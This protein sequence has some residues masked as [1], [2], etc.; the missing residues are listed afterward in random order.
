MT[1][2]VRT[3]PVPTNGALSI[4]MLKFDARFTK[5]HL[6]TRRCD[7][8]RNRPLFAEQPA[9]PSRSRG[10][11]RPRQ[12]LSDCRDNDLQSRLQWVHSIPVLTTPYTR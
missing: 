2:P 4:L 6:I 12:Q 7:C 1:G 10:P 9:N 11:P 3:M 8:L 5:R